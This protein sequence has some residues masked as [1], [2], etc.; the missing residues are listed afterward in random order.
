MPIDSQEHADLPLATSFGARMM[1]ERSPTDLIAATRRVGA[2]CLIEHLIM[3]DWGK[4][5]P[6]YDT[7]LIRDF[8]AR[9]AANAARQGIDV[10]LSIPEKD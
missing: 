4:V 9:V 1:P 7:P 5:N 10:K 6:E 3:G 2:H 8:L